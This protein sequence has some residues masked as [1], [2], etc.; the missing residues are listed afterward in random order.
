[1]QEW[2]RYLR[3][4]QG[5]TQAVVATQAGITQNYYSWIEI[6]KR[7]PSVAVAKRLAEVLHCR[8]TDF[9]L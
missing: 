3:L 6:G 1:M 2:L 8:W 7:Q 5:Y 9:Y 4:Q